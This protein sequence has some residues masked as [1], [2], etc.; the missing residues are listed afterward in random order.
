MPI[1]ADNSPN[2]KFPLPAV[3]PAF[4]IE[5]VFSDDIFN[6]IKKKVT[7]IQWGP[8]GNFFYHTSLGR[9]ESNIEFD[10]DL[11]EIILQ[12]GRDAYQD[13]TLLTAYH[14]VVRY[15]KQNGNI[16]HLWKH[17][18]QNGCQQT[19]D[20]CIEKEG[21]EWGLEV[22][23][24]VFSEKPNDAICFYGQQQVHSRP[25]FPKDATENDW[26]TVLFFHFVKPDHWFA[27]AREEGG[28]EMVA[29]KFSEYGIDG[30]VRYFEATGEYAAPQLPDGQERCPCHSYFEVP[31]AVKG[32]VNG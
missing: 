32:I 8:E 26:L 3:K 30:D 27:K 29:K 11:E 23:G 5:N 18:D 16:P 25:D 21:V 2:I 9:W 19:I 15:Q 12:T 31:N 6:R 17:M 24:V 22:D 20:I 7:E 14:Y 13:P 1:H 28:Q 10:P 4:K